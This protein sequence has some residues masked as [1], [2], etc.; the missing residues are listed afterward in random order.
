MCCSYNC[1]NLILF[2]IVCFVLYKA[3]H[4]ILFTLIVYWNV[5]VSII[6]VPS[7]LPRF[8]YYSLFCTSPSRPAMLLHLTLFCILYNSICV[9][10]LI[11]NVEKNKNKNCIIYTCPYISNFLLCD[12]SLRLMN[13]QTDG[14]LWGL[15]IILHRFSH[16][17]EVIDQSHSHL[18]PP[19]DCGRKP[20][21]EKKKLHTER[22]SW[23]VGSNPEPFCCEVTTTILPFLTVN[24]VKCVFYVK[25]PFTLQLLV[26]FRC[27]QLTALVFPFVETSVWCL[28]SVCWKVWYVTIIPW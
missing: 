20:T 7:L 25:H 2:I 16:T 18:P 17:L 1:A 15:D 9:T 3:V 13:G 26:S 14:Q 5:R 19:L 24:C 6:T 22:L 11:Y 12:F 8:T 28:C 21:Q 23:L 4:I 27:I 10:V